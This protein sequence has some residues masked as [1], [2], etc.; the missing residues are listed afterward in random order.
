[1]H[2]FSSCRWRQVVGDSWQGKARFCAQGLAG[3][4]ST[5]CTTAA[6]MSWTR[7]PST[8]VMCSCMLWSHTLCTCSHC[9]CAWRGTAWWFRAQQQLAAGCTGKGTLQRGLAQGLSS[10]RR[11]RAELT[12]ACDSDAAA[13]TLSRS[14]LAAATTKRAEVCPE[15]HHMALHISQ[16]LPPCYML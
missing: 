8:S 7:C 4:K 9:G 5:V 13:Q 3:Q 14:S 2:V 6:G 16:L 15:V 1:M 12:Q 10:R 11:G